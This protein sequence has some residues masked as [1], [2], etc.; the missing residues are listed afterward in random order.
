MCC[1][2]YVL[3]RWIW[4]DTISTMCITGDY[5][6]ADHQAKPIK[7]GLLA[8]SE[9]WLKSCSQLL[10]GELEYEDFIESARITAKY[11]ISQGAE[12]VL[13]ITHSR[14]QNDYKLM[15]E[16]PEI[17]LLLGGHDHFF[18]DDLGKRIIKSGEE[19]RWLSKIRIDIAPGGKPIVTYE[20]EDITSDIPED[21]RINALCD[22]YQELC[23]QKF[24]KVLCQTALELNPTEE[25]VRFKESAVCNWVCDVCC[26]DYSL[27]DGDQSADICLLQ[28]FSFAGKAAI[29]PGDYTLGNLMGMFP[30]SLLLCV[31]ELSGEAIVGILNKGVEA[32]PEECGSI[33]HVNSRLAYSVVLPSSENGLKSPEVKD[34][35]YEGNPIDIKRVYKVAVSHKVLKV[36]E[37]YGYTWYKDAPEIV[38]EEHASQVS[39]VVIMYCNKHKDCVINPSLGRIKMT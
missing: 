17:T 36:A 23:E 38:E 21:L 35:L 25:F 1:V 29:P 32:L 9:N 39:D 34:V 33:H 5:G 26:E 24:K 4:C 37:K 22:K 10:P 31:V 8:V 19:W 15:E 12:V 28:G 13:A 27:Y 11:L 3:L 16:V 2:I 14:L 20:R 30:L 7:V 6:S 18:K